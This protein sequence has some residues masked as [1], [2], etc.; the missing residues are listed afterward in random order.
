MT[1]NSL[2]F[3]IFLPIVFGLYWLPVSG[4]RRED[5]QNAVLSAAASVFYAIWDWRVLG[6]FVFS[7]VFTMISVRRIAKQREIRCQWGR[8]PWKPSFSATLR[9]GIVSSF[10]PTRVSRALAGPVVQ[11]RRRMFIEMGNKRLE[12]IVRL[13]AGAV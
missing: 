4:K 3:L 7:V 5:Y 2:A 6:L 8:T 13:I 1:F 12:M 9:F 11:K 10:N